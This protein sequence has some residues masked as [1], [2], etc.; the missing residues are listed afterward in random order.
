[1][2]DFNS[3]NH[4]HK[5]GYI[6]YCLLC[7]WKEILCLS[8]SESFDQIIYSSQKKCVCSSSFHKQKDVK[9]C[10]TKNT[11]QWDCTHCSFKLK[12]I[13][14]QLYLYRNQST[15]DYEIFHHCPYKKKSYSFSESYRNLQC[16][17]CKQQ[18]KQC[19]SVGYSWT[20]HSCELSHPDILDD[21]ISFV[22]NETKCNDK[23]MS[24]VCWQCN[25]CNETQIHLFK[26]SKRI[27]KNNLFKM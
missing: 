15:E 8:E 25:K 7:W 27:P 24:G 1:M 3:L 22:V 9:I 16:F 2:Y 10:I 18:Q 21:N 19:T 12:S 13:V 6:K 5:Y 11:I 23:K 26:D 14:R 20:C 4:V 17:K